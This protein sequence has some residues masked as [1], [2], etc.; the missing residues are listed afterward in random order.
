MIS[1]MSSNKDLVAL[2]SVE[3]EYVAAC[4]VGK[5][6]VQ[7]RKLLTIF[8]EK[9]LGPTMINCGNQSC[10]KM[11]GDLM[12]HAR[13]KHINN[14]FHVIRNLVQVGIMKLEYVSTDEQVAGILTKALPNK[15]FEYLRNLLGL[16]DIVDC[17]DDKR[18]EEIY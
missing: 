8:F 12:F 18:L 2:S 6:V 17:I 1:W 15:K 4:E 10:I 3:A 14:K 9:S 16:V 13:T 7:L 5:E 11:S